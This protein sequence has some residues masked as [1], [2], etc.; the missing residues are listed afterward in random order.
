MQTIYKLRLLS[1]EAETR[2][3]LKPHT[4]GEYRSTE[5]AEETGLG[6]PP[7]T[8]TIPD[9]GDNA[10]TKASV[11]WALGHVKEEEDWGI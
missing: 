11:Q 3:C 1:L 7:V 10:L 6:V 2:P 5:S 9:R 4:D 8:G